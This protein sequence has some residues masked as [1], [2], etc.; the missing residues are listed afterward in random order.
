MTGFSN[1][2]TGENFGFE[3]SFYASLF[4]NQVWEKLNQ[5]PDQMGSLYELQSLQ[6][7]ET[8]LQTTE[9]WSPD[10][11]CDF[12]S[13]PDADL[14]QLADPEV[15]ELTGQRQDQYSAIRNNL[16]KTV[17]LKRQVT[18]EPFGTQAFHP[19]PWQSSAVVFVSG[20]C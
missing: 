18:S 19:Q 20:I 15:D 6:Q 12:L 5:H 17:E 4:S 13:Q 14:R 8:L 2:S 9:D 7:L 1:G 3:D 16:F 10:Q 11:W